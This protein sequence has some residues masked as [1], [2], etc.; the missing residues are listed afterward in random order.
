MSN[1][2]IE[3]GDNVVWNFVF[4]VPEECGVVVDVNDDKVKVEYKGWKGKVYRDWLDMD[5]VMLESE[6]EFFVMFEDK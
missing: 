4:G 2:E 3:I 6:Y 5:Q 1:E